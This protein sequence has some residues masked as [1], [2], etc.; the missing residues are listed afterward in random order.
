M[1][2]LSRIFSWSRRRQRG[3]E[4]LEFG[5]VLLVMV[6]MLLGTFITGLSIVRAIQTNQMDRDLTDM[7]IHGADFSTYPLQQMAQRLGRGLNLQIGSVFAGHQATNTSNTGDGLVT[8]TQL[9]YIGTTTDPTCLA[10]PLGTCTNHDKFVF[11][12]RIQ[13]GNGGLNAQYPSSLGSPG[14]GA[15]MTSA[16]FVQNYVTDVN[17]AL[18]SAAQAG[19]QSL[20]QVSGG[21][22]TPLTD[23]RVIYVVE[24]YI[25]PLNTGL[26][27]YSNG[28]VFARYFF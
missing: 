17:A 24:T 10:V 13:F 25:Q 21:G 18:P 22:R 15:S 19:M 7:Y 2:I 27:I 26:N 14:G 16:G 12:Q 20:W 9:M 23:G 5:L 1:T 4:L 6:P 3:Q 11:T 8:V 28:A